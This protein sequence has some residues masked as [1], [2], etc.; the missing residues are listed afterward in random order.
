[1]RRDRICVYRKNLDSYAVCDSCQLD[2]T[3]ILMR[4][5]HILPYFAAMEARFASAV[6]LLSKL[7][8]FIE[9]DFRNF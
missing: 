7:Q 8:D 9:C 2:R 6:V 5:T 1:L 4:R 3:V